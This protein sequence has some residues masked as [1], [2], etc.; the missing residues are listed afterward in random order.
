MKKW[1]ENSIYVFFG[2]MILALLIII[3]FFQKV[4]YMCKPAYVIPNIIIV[5]ILPV[6]IFL[7]ICAK[8]LIKK[9]L[10]SRHLFLNGI[11]SDRFVKR[12]VIVLFFLQIYGCYNMIF[13]SDWDVSVIW[14]ASKEYAS[15][16]YT[17]VAEN[18]YFQQYPN[19]LLFMMIQSLLIK[20][21]TWFG[22]FEG[23]RGQLMSVAMLNCFISSGTCFLVYKSAKL[24]CSVKN[25]LFAFLISILL[26]GISP[27]AAINY[28]DAIS[29]MFPVL[30]FYLYVC[31]RSCTWRKKLSQ[32]GAIFIGC[33]S[34]F[35]KPQCFIMVIAILLLAI[36][37][38]MK[39]SGYL[40]YLVVVSLYL[41]TFLCLFSINKSM[42]TVLESN[43]IYIDE[44]NKFGVSHFL[45][46]GMNVERN[47]IFSEKDVAFSNSF[48]TSKERIEA[49]LNTAI[50]R[51]NEMGSVGLFK[52]LVK[53]MLVTFS[54]GMFAWGMEGVFFYQI[55]DCPNNK[56]APFIRAL[57]YRN[58]EY[59]MIF[60]TFEQ[61]IWIM[62]LIL[63]ACSSISIV[64]GK[65]NELLL[66]MLAL[67]GL[68]TYLLLFE[69][70]ARYLYTYIPIYCILAAVGKQQIQITVQSSKL[71]LPKIFQKNYQKT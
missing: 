25:S 26:V 64:N 21:H 40:N 27:W 50:K 8:K 19:N 66:L 22:I 70:R 43:D 1:I 33:F 42:H 56:T 44:E 53:K 12:I 18:Y 68:T 47:G 46:M 13:L 32:F 67:I 30:T 36:L 15:G 51:V 9:I 34:Y 63:C 11:E 20:F 58:G 5:A 7:G 54:D 55:Y 39:K 29:L 6:I 28:S 3:S 57:F 61:F 37:V 4:S 65:R 24:L 62:V 71:S 17:K 10:K 48:T 38:D 16:N 59:R 23:E 31:P 49:N 60:A 52:H 41:C 35:L 45:M 69:A 2:I 14:K